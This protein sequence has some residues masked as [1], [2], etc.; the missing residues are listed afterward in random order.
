MKFIH[1]LSTNSV[2]KVTLCVRVWIEIQVRALFL[3][4][5]FVTL[6]VRVWIE[7]PSAS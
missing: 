3:S 7:I 2:L 5:L 1:K 6:C 4:A